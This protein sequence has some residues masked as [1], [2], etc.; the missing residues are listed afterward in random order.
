M[1]KE[2]YIERP[3]EKLIYENQNICNGLKA[4]KILIYT[5]YSY[6]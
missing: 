5:R 4:T 2:N 6:R 3:R 1:E